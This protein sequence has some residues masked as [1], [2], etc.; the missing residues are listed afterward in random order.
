MGRSR[1][2]S[3]NA[4][5]LAV[6]GIFFLSGA[7]A[8]TYQLLWMRVLGLIFGVTVYAASTVWASFMAGLAVGSV[9]A[10]RLADR[11][12]R[13]L[14]W[15]G[16]VEGAIALTGTITTLAFSALQ[17]WYP[18]LVPGLAGSFVH[19]TAIRF[20]VAFLLMILPTALMGATLPFVV[21]A[22]TRGGYVA[23]IGVL[24]GSNT[25]GAIAGALAAGLWLIPIRGMRATFV[26][27]AS[28]NVLAALSAVF[29]SRARTASE[30]ADV[31]ID[32]DERMSADALSPASRKMV[33]ATFTVSGA[34][35]LALEVIWL[36]SATIILGPT[37]YTVAVLLATIL[38]GI[39]LG[40]YCI[41][42]LLVRVR[43]PL[44]VLAALEGLIAFAILASLVTLTKT[45]AVVDAVPAS[46]KAL[47]PPYLMPVIVGGV[48]VALPT[49]WLMGLAFPLGLHVW[50]RTGASEDGRSGWRLG[51]FYSLNVC[52]GV[53]GSLGAGFVL[54]PVVGTRMGLDMLAGVTLATSV[55][56]ILVAA[57]SWISR[58]FVAVAAVTMFMVVGA[59]L[60]DPVTTLLALRVPGQ[61]VV[62]VEEGIQTT[63]S[64]HTF[65]GG[66]RSAMYLDGYHQAANDGATL[67][68]HYKIGTLPVALH[69]NP[70][71]ALV[72]GLGGGA[73]A[74]AMSRHS[75]LNVDVV[76]LS[77]TV[78]R[79]SDFFRQA[80]FDLLTRPNVRLRIDDGR[81]Y[82]V[83]T[84][85]RYDII[86]ADT[87]QPVRAGSASL[88]S[89]EYFTLVRD[90]LNE[91]GV[92]LQWFGGTDG[93]YRLVARTFADVFPYVTLWDN[94]TLLVGTKRPLKLS[95]ETFNWKLKVPGLSEALAAIDIRS[96]E[97]LLHEF[98]GGP[99]DLRD[100]LGDGAVLTDDRPILEY[101]L[102]MRRDKEVETSSFKG[103]VQQI[104]GE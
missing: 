35:A 83:S 14:L 75:G 34:V 19:A 39:A 45:P 24:Y 41:T 15:F 27:A 26:V 18:R 76:E 1:H 58:L 102:T 62:W 87:I 57:R 31:A 51:I 77:N 32:S 60:S 89:K 74:G 12:K 40:S 20:V 103:N 65:L 50:T 64:I 11:A 29:L 5:L 104:L 81:N 68:L 28:L 79:A 13:P 23:A 91:D 72:V 98:W 44:I 10:G 59:R 70:H 56:L 82:L 92:A 61:P 97:D 6:C 4:W 95:P 17:H 7:S 30:I 47:V 16:G 67:R 96:F 84:R 54:L 99:S 94:G 9:I 100:H 25:S 48:L 101:F 85:R 73:T 46:L 37:V 88:Y 90:R 52:A 36:R 55:G 8:L 93:E 53:V 78:V 21:T 22:A 69:P 33:L 49:S 71:T 3:V 42:P 38:A 2:Q 80:N 43:R 63:A 66:R 86:T